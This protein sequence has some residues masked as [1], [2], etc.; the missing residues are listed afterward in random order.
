[1]NKYEFKK[2]YY[3]KDTDI[4]YALHCKYFDCPSFHVYIIIAMYGDDMHNVWVYDS[5]E[6]ANRIMDKFLEEVK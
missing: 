6:R 3:Y 5:L 4:R 2:W 1:M